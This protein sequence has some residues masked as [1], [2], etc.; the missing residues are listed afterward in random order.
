M[1]E[2]GEVGESESERMLM[3]VF[4]LIRRGGEM[5]LFV[6]F[7]WLSERC[8]FYVFLLLAEHGRC[9]DSWTLLMFSN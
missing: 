4:R 9:L 7:C 3:V 2:V 6:D 5:C 8:S 1:V